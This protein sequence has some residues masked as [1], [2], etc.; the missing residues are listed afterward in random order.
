M[1]DVEGTVNYIGKKVEVS[2]T[3]LVRENSIKGKGL[4]KEQ[5][6]VEVI[7]G[8]YTVSMEANFGGG[9]NRCGGRR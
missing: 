8:T 1:G 9:N 3:A 2:H 5:G 4:V 6:S 7:T